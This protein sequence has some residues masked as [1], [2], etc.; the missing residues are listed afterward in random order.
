MSTMSKFI[1]DA[2]TRK[3]ID[4][5][6]K[7]YSL[8]ITGK[9]GTGKTMLLRKIVSE[10]EHDKKVAIAAPTGVA[11][12]N[13][14]GVTL[15]SLFRLPL[16]IYLPG[17]SVPK[18]HNQSP[19]KKAFLR[20]L[21]LLII[22][23]VSMVRCDVLDMVDKVLKKCRGNQEP[24][25]GL[26]VVMFGDLRQLM[27]VAKDEEEK[28]LRD[29]YESLYFFSSKVMESCNIPMLELTTVH[30]QNDS[31]F[32]GM[33]NNIRDGILTRQDSIALNKRIKYNF[34]PSDSEHYIRLTTHKWKAKWYNNK[35]MLELPSEERIYDGSIEGFYSYLDLPADMH[36]TLKKGARVMFVANDNETG[37]YVNGTLGVVES[38]GDNKI[39]V[40]TDEGN[41]IHVGCREWI[42][43][44]YRINKTTKEVEQ[45][46]VGAYVQFPLKLAWAI[47]IHKSQGLT[48]D[49]AVIDAGKSFAPGQVYVALSRCRTLDSIVL[50]SRITQDVVSIDPIVEDYIDN[51]ERIDLNADYPVFDEEIEAEIDD[52]LQ[53]IVQVIPEEETPTF[54]SPFPPFSLATQI[55]KC[56]YERGPIKAKDIANILGK[57]RRDINSELTYIVEPTGL[58]SK[59]EDYFWSYVGK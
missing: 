3:A 56:I 27:P 54:T 48:F 58:V 2:A 35:R 53:V 11:A 31:S 37:Q 23:E 39:T 12:K 8:F 17:H 40:F 13:A 45:Y 44:D 24:F 50:A 57:T 51:V 55:F 30:R 52:E 9:A 33:L 18:L 6:H 21:D 41:L 46:R 47:T 15:H 25:G 5:I 29:Y 26:Q 16:S 14:G 59:S 28:E 36:L 10:L 7:G 42:N 20:Q 22:D 4:L 34:Y 32:I 43:Y 1:H 19:Q 49:R 38:L